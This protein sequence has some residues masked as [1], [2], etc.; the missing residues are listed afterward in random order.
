MKSKYWIA[1]KGHGLLKDIRYEL[2]KEVMDMLYKVSDQTTIR[3][4]YDLMEEA[5]SC[6]LGN[7]YHAYVLD[8]PVLYSRSPNRYVIERERY[9]YE[10]Y[11][12]GY[13]VR[14]VDAMYKLGFICGVKGKKVNNGQYKPSKMWA[15]EDLFE[16]LLSANGSVFLKRTD[17]VI[18]LKDS[19]KLLIQYRDNQMTRSMRR[20]LCELNEMLSSLNLTFTF[21]Y[22]ELSD[23]ATARINKLA[24]LRSLVLV[25]QVHIVPPYD[26]LLTTYETD[27]YK[28]TYNTTIYYNA[29]DHDD[30][31]TNKFNGFEVNCM[32]NSDANLMKRVF[33]VDWHHGGRFYQAPHI[34]IPSACRQTIVINGEPTVELDFSGMHIRMLYHLTDKDYRGEC[35]VHE[36][37]DEVNK[38]DRE[39]IKLASL[40]VINSGDRAKAIRAIHNECRK[41]DIHYPKGGF[42]RYNALL[43]SFEKHHEPIEQFFYTKKGR[44]LQ[45]QDSTIMANILSRMT[46]QNIPALPVHDSVICPVRHEDFLRQV[47]IEEYEKVMDFEPVID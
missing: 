4:N 21:S 15:T 42:Y 9:G 19:G 16:L 5:Y 34:T 17:E 26:V 12:R 38:L 20:Q 27:R 47:M 25:N 39:R 40:I 1:T 36:K 2:V 32:V 10:W 41:K 35:Y 14:L 28:T 30:F 29:N 44:E 11:T 3:G 6:L 8:E 7:L 13:I 31:L 45:Y 33:N 43:D 23:R 18:F 22:P 24:K 37:S 46:K